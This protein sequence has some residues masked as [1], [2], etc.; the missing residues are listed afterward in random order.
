MEIPG[1]SYKIAVVQT[2]NMEIDSDSV[3]LTITKVI[4]DPSTL[5]DADRAAFE[6]SK[7]GEIDFLLK[8]AV[9]PIPVKGVP[10]SV[11]IQPLKWLLALKTDIEDSKKKRHQ[12]RIVSATHRAL[13]RHSVHGNTPK[14]MLSTVR[15]F[16]CIVPTWMELSPGDK[17]VV[18]GRDVTKAFIQSFESQRPII[19]MPPEEYFKAYPH[20]ATHVWRAYMQI[21]GEVEAGLYW[22]RTFVPWLI[23]NIADIQQSV[24][25]PSPLFSP[26]KLIAVL[27]CTDDT[28][29]AMSESYVQSEA[30]IEK[31]FECRERQFL[32][33]DFK[34]VDVLKEGSNLVMSQMAYID[35]KNKDSDNVSA[36]TVTKPDLHRKLNDGEVTQ[37]RTATGRLAWVATGTSPTYACLDSTALQGK[38]KTVS[39]LQSCR[40]AYNQLAVDNLAS[41]RFVPLDFESIHIRVFSDSSF[42][43]LPDKHSQIGFIFTLADK[44]DKTNIFHWHSSRATRRPTSTEEAELFALD[45]ALQRLRN[46]RKIVFQLLQKEV[47]AVVYIDNQTLWQNL[48]NTTAPSLPEVMLR[49]RDHINDETVNSVCLIHTAY[50]PADAMTKKKPNSAL[51]NTIKRIEHKV[52]VKRVFMLQHSLYRHSSFI[53]TSHVPMKE[54][55]P[56]STSSSSEQPTPSPVSPPP[57]ILTV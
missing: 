40:K 46:Q 7:K 27:L 45:V 52:P 57:A 29:I 20:F 43:N 41:L 15:I 13:L 48:M 56:T 53:P 3:H 12:A 28:L 11:Q 26:T 24:Y 2:D 21:Y 35:T 30:A 17:V 4:K 19:H 38:K 9:T 32:P 8:H 1:T 16:C 44:H 18:F 33:T 6:V 55:I 36:K 5:N 23:E 49:C 39:L 25:D 31:R 10:P 47:P 37:H 22:H 51:V 50:N 42:Q 54:D 34:G 14:V